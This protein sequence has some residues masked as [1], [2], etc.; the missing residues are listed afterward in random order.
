[1]GVR[2]R[3]PINWFKYDPE[4]AV[5]IVD[6]TIM[7]VVASRMLYPFKPT[8]VIRTKSGFYAW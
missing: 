4:M 5:R 3:R 2:R 6:E 7:E 1:M 8:E